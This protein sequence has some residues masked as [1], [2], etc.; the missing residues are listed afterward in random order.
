M[1]LWRTNSRPLVADIGTVILISLS[2][3]ALPGI[4]AVAQTAKVEIE[5]TPTE[6]TS[7]SNSLG[8]STSNPPI[9]NGEQFSTW[10]LKEQQTQN[11]KSASD[12]TSSQSTLPFSPYYLGTSWQTPK[13]LNDQNIDKQ[14]ALNSLEQIRFSQNDPADQ[15][16]KKAFTKLIESLKVTGRVPLPNTNPRYL[17]ANPKLDPILG[18]GDRITIPEAPNTITVIRS[19][20][21]LCKIRYRPNIETRHY[22]DGCKLRGKNEERGAD[23]AWVV[24]PDGSIHK[25]S[26]AAWNSSKQDLPAPGSWIWAPPRWSQWTNSS[27]EQFTKD[28]VKILSVQGP[29]GLEQGIDTQTSTRGSLPSIDPQELYSVSRDLPISANVWGET[30]LLQTPSA[31]TAPA[32][33]AAATLGLYQPYG[34]LNLYFAPL[35]GVEFIMRYTNINNI[36]YGEQSLSGGQTYKDKSTGLKVKLLNENAYLPEIAVGARDLLGTGLFSGEYFVANKRHNNF[37]FS[38]GM[39]WGQLGTRNNVT[40]PFVTAFGQNYATRPAVSTNQGGTSTGGFFHGTAAMFG[41]VQYHTPWEN[42]VLKAE[43][44]GNNYQQL[45]F[46]NTL[47]VKSIFNFGATYQTKYA[48]FTV[49]SLGN[50]QVMFILSLH[51]RLDLLS[52]PKLAEAK[53]INVDLKPV[54]S[55]SP[56]NPNLLAVTNN[57]TNNQ[58]NIQTTKKYTKT[59]SDLSAT[60]TP[61]NKGTLTTQD[62]DL[63]K[64]ANVSES[65]QAQA[66]LSTGSTS[67]NTALTG[68]LTQAYNDTLLEFEKQTQ[69]QVKGLRGTDRTWTIHLLDASGVF[70]RSRINRGVTVLHRDAPTDVENFKIQFYNWGML[71]SEFNIDRK[72]WMLS[73]T[74]LLPPSERRPSITT[75]NTA[76]LP[77]DGGN[78]FF[79]KSSKDF[80]SIGMTS[81]S[82]NNSINAATTT[83][84][85]NL[86]NITTAPAKEDPYFVDELNHKPLQ[87]NLGVSYSQIVGSPDSPFLFAFGVKA[88]ALYKFRENTWITGTVNA[89]VVDNFGKYN[90][91][92]PPTG[93]QPVRTDIRQYMTQSIATMPNLQVTNTGKLADNHFVSAY[94]GYLETMFAGAGGEYLY[95]PT[96]S[97]IAVGADINRVRQRQF[98]VWTSMQ[99]YAVTTGHVTGYWDT[100]VQDIL[101]KMS[102]GKYLAG[103]IGGTLDLSRVFANGVKIG[104]YAT[105]TN[106]N[107]TQFGEGSF[108]K[109]LYLSVPFDAFFAKHSDSVANLLFTPLIRDG[110]AMLYRK[111]KLYD[112]TRTRDDRALSAGPD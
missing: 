57:Q 21:T 80:N 54:G 111:Y 103:D 92:P 95:R 82:S 27:G 90:Y 11:T 97:K 43:I 23:W 10:M 75:E 25:V 79:R 32:G 99:N 37:D 35:N 1:T 73:Q 29:S 71:V 78:P 65:N 106:V 53:A 77:A 64:N 14:A 8:N 15:R 5:S 22:V 45:P 38:L 105:R 56:T 31:R 69:W 102:Y 16:S 68:N 74:Q 24:E 2:A 72:Q 51:E 66:N 30:G 91:D 48:D 83:N 52:T 61:N 107:Y 44:D 47:P 87:T 110:G 104:A 17:E 93:L 112:M 88:D 109:G 26:L 98:N 20:G 86:A 84:A 6:Q 7:S 36:P 70:L 18:N 12:S 81:S 60:N 34:V 4:N 96:N 55:Y 89:R 13:E 33:T 59:P 58:A 49:G 108:D 76:S 39:G 3:F 46:S 9:V 28:F 63:V 50:S 94:A 41:G 85:T 101:V 67:E 62:A 100:G 40:N 42:L 19:N